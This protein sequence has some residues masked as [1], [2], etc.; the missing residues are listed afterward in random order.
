[1]VKEWG[2]KMFSSF[3]KRGKHFPHFWRCFVHWGKMFFMVSLFSVKRTSEN[4]ENIFSEVIFHETNGAFVHY[5][6]VSNTRD[7]FLENI[8]QII[9]FLRNKI[10]N[11]ESI[12]L[13]WS[14]VS[15]TKL[16]KRKWL[17]IIDSKNIFLMN[18]LSDI[19]NYF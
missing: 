8:F 6:F 2:G 5:L 17:I 13:K 11:L 1:M 7:T 16:N 12:F 19:N 3:Q 14:L 18:F 10:N 15:L 4:S 9:H